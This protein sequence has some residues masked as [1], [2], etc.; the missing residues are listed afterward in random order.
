MKRGLGNLFPKI[1][2]LEQS[3]KSIGQKVEHLSGRPVAGMLSN[4][5][6]FKKLLA[7]HSMEI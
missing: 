6:E 1:F 2:S 4:E 7:S 3:K 5:E